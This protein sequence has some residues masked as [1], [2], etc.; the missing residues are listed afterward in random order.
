ML[1]HMSRDSCIASTRVTIE[2]MNHFGIPAKPL[3]VFTAVYNAAYAL[4]YKAMGNRWPKDE[5][6]LERW[7]AECGAQS[8]GI[9]Y[10]EGPPEAG[11]WPGH[12]VAVVNN[13][14]LVDASVDQVEQCQH[15]IFLPGTLSERVTRPF[16]AGKEWIEVAVHPD[17]DPDYKNSSIVRYRLC[18]E[19]PPYDTSPDWCDP[20]RAGPIVRA[21]LTAM[22][23]A[24]T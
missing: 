2:V 23:A 12:L 3:P 15:G 18:H 5:D 9:G 13:R 8:I 19:S 21:I 6:E 10:H 7:H 20:R 1:E 16:L 22:G 11:K 17:S 4:R 14:F 24:V